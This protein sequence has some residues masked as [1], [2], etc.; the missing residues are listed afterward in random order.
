MKFFTH[1][2]F[3]VF[4]TY[5]YIVFCEKLKIG[6]KMLFITFWSLSHQCLP[7]HTPGFGQMGHTYA[8]VN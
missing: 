3:I 6:K 1:F 8:L 2:S 4:K 7:R 5:L